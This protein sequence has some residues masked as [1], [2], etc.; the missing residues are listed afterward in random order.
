MMNLLKTCVF[1]ALLTATAVAQDQ[2]SGISWNIGIPTGQ[3][4]SYMNKTSYGGIGLEFGR[5]VDDNVS[6]GASFSWNVW[7]NLTGEIINLKNGAVS[8]TQIRYYN[9]FPMLLN[10]H[11]YLSESKHDPFKPYIGLNAGFYYILQRMDIGAYSLQNDNWHFGLAPEAGFLLEVS[12]RT[13]LTATA[14]YNY[15]FDAG[16]T[17]G[18]KDNNSLAYWGVNVGLV[19]YT[20]WF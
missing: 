5:Y 7:S 11:Y 9:A 13:Y 4:S 3:M 10:A 15:A 20:G 1:A 19:W 6:V 18:G 17:L 16:T 14:R 2:M 8:G 12:N